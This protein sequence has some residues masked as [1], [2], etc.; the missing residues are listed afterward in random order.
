MADKSLFERLK[1]LFSSS[2]RKDEEKGVEMSGSHASQGVDVPESQIEAAIQVESKVKTALATLGTLLNSLFDIETSKAT[3]DQTQK[4]P[5]DKVLQEVAIA[6]TQLNVF[7]SEIEKKTDEIER[8]TDEVQPEELQAALSVYLANRPSSDEE[9]Q[10]ILNDIDAIAD[11][12]AKAM[13]SAINSAD[14]D[15]HKVEFKLIAERL[16]KAV[17]AVIAS[18]ETSI[19]QRGD[20]VDP[21]NEFESE[22]VATKDERV[23]REVLGLDKS[24]TP[25][26]I[27]IGKAFR[28]QVMRE[29]LDP[30]RSEDTQRLQ[31]LSD[32]KVLLMKGVAPPGVNSDTVALGERE[33]ASKSS[34]SRAIQRFSSVQVVPENQ[35]VV[36][37]GSGTLV[38]T[39][40]LG[41]PQKNRVPVVVVSSGVEG[42]NV[43]FANLPFD[44]KASLTHEIK[45]LINN[46]SKNQPSSLIPFVLPKQNDQTFIQFL[47]TLMSQ[48]KIFYPAT[49]NADT[50]EPHPQVDEFGDLSKLQVVVYNKPMS[51]AEISALLKE[52]LPPNASRE[53]REAVEEAGDTLVEFVE[54]ASKS[55]VVASALFWQALKVTRS[56]GGLLPDN[57]AALSAGVVMT[58]V[59]NDIYTNS[60]TKEETEAVPQEV[61]DSV[62]AL[63]TGVEEAAREE[64]EGDAQAVVAYNAKQAEEQVSEHDNALSNPDVSIVVSEFQPDGSVAYEIKL[65]EEIFRRRLT[66]PTGLFSS[67]DLRTAIQRDA[68]NHGCNLPLTNISGSTEESLLIEDGPGDNSA[69]VSQSETPSTE[70]LSGAA[71]THGV[72]DSAPVTDEEKITKFKAQ[73]EKFEAL[74]VD[75]SATPY[76][77]ADSDSLFL[78]PKVKT[79]AKEALASLKGAIGA[80]STA[81]EDFDRVKEKSDDN[82]FKVRLKGAKE[83][84]ETGVGTAI[85]NVEEAI[86]ELEAAVVIAVEFSAYKDKAV[87]EAHAT[88]STFEEKLGT[89]PDKLKLG[90][91]ANDAIKKLEKAIGDY[92]DGIAGQLNDASSW[93]KIKK[94]QSDLETKASAVN[95]AIRLA[96]QA[97]P[98]TEALVIRSAS[99]DKPNGEVIS[100]E[101]F[102]TMM[103]DAINVASSK[104]IAPDRALKVEYRR[105]SLLYHPDKH[106]EKTAEFQS[107]NS[108]HQKVLSTIVDKMVEFFKAQTLK[109]RDDF[110]TQHSQFLKELKSLQTALGDTSDLDEPA[111]EAAKKAVAKLRTSISKYSS[112]ANASFSLIGSE[113]DLIEAQSD[114]EEQVAVVRDNLA[115]A[116]QAIENMRMAQEDISVEQPVAESIEVDE[117]IDEEI[118][119][120]LNVTDDND[121]YRT[122]APAFLGYNTKLMNTKKEINDKIDINVKDE[123][124]KGKNKEDLE[125]KISGI[126]GALKE[127]YNAIIVL[128]GSEVESSLECVGDLFEGMLT[129]LETEFDTYFENLQIADENTL[130]ER[131]DTLPQERGVEST[132]SDD[133]NIS[134]LAKSVN[135]EPDFG[136]VLRKL[137]KKP[138]IERTQKNK[139]SFGHKPS[140]EQDEEL[141]KSAWVMRG[142]FPQNTI[143]RLQASLT[144]I[145]DEVEAF[146]KDDSSRDAVQTIKRLQV[147]LASTGK[148]VDK[149]EKSAQ[150]KGSKV[151]P[152]ERAQSD[153]A[154]ARL[155][156]Q[157]K[158]L[159]QALKAIQAGLVRAAALKA[160]PRSAA[161]YGQ[162]F[163]SPEK[164][165]QSER[166]A[167]EA[168]AARSASVH[169]PELRTE[170]DENDQFGDFQSAKPL[171]EEDDSAARQKKHRHLRKSEI[172]VRTNPKV[173]Q[174]PAGH[175]AL[176]INTTKQPNSEVLS[177]DATKKLRSNVDALKDTLKKDE[178][179]ERKYVLPLLIE[180]YRALKA[181]EPGSRVVREK[182]VVTIHLID[183]TFDENEVPRVSSPRTIT[184]GPDVAPVTPLTHLQL[185]EKLDAEL[186]TLLTKN[187]DRISDGVKA[188]LVDL[189][190]VVKHSISEVKKQATNIENQHV[191]KGE[192]KGFRGFSKLPFSKLPENTSDLDNT[193]DPGD[194]PAIP[195]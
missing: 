147:S 107:L 8:D 40:G 16:K 102:E 131:E 69:A 158:E 96:S 25:D 166:L 65:R 70:D 15:K 5:I 71:M 51:L 63:I 67:Y 26:T 12:V 87:E 77:G 52:E 122:V 38:T 127:V 84:A 101:A 72:S 14:T 173:Q 80:Y 68:V 137:K 170:F 165:E 172:P 23:A 49:T 91:K 148:E 57:T 115:E 61:M 113:E 149:L 34:L 59:A 21:T 106:P 94:A 90:T 105:L 154:I 13:K 140:D 171:V 46:S 184:K 135:A 36:K 58:V 82:K 163:L 86:K 1:D 108:A 142:R 35:V 47:Q 155:I 97:A 28:D 10:P 9:H 64:L 104:Q 181:S 174:Q 195:G 157:K 6:I 130:M 191:F 62:Q 161:K 187:G 22:P 17:M 33:T 100:E 144:S 24:V 20:D 11:A 177:A 42:P 44:P 143:T 186:N 139:T 125:K 53:N 103:N 114:L 39:V 168:K 7:S 167:A 132:E 185:L 118:D 74:I 193:E 32:A 37:P 60:F 2:I 117:E 4:D 189:Q 124:K 194:S 95:E 27:S 178:D 110:K 19:V 31:A 182:L 180:S 169:T 141:M 116:N 192:V 66:I 83:T 159:D 76:L 162:Q 133:V 123:S 54:K 92:S 93:V 179:F 153:E 109:V 55:N 81:L 75:A 45:Q 99:D 134:S 156:A 111:T 85:K 89:F 145:A 29:D 79:T 152:V 151:Q 136:S 56:M 176:T 175:S 73:L 3:L 183:K 88:L 150:H 48:I 164:Q 128:D 129:D 188:G 126:K 98:S 121:I 120:G 78:V 50:S 30:N 138:G 112:L 190:V 18:A 119:E 43:S 160:G 41:T 146:K